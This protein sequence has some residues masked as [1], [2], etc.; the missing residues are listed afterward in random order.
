MCCFK[1]LI[2]E[3]ESISP[4]MVVL[5]PS[6]PLSYVFFSVQVRKQFTS[7]ITNLSG[8]LGTPPYTLSATGHVCL[9]RYD[10]VLQRQRAR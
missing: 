8:D 2:Q 9:V 6:S 10:L 5:S 1:I 3:V 7:S 4:M